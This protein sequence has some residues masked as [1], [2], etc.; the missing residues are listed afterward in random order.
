LTVVT[1]QGAG[2]GRRSLS[3]PLGPRR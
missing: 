1:T 2:H 3:F